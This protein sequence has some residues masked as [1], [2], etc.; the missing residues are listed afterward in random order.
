MDNCRSFGIGKGERIRIFYRRSGEKALGEVYLGD[1]RVGILSYE[2]LSS[3]NGRVGR[4]ELDPSH[5][6]LERLLLD[7]AL[8]DL[9]SKAKGKIY[10]KAHPGIVFLLLKY[11]FKPDLSI[12]EIQEM[13]HPRN[14]VRIEEENGGYKIS[15]REGFQKEFIQV[16]PKER[17]SLRERG[18]LG[19]HLAELKEEFKEGNVLLAGMDYVVDRGDIRFEKKEFSLSEYFSLKPSHARELSGLC[20]LME[21]RI[22]ATS[23]SKR[24]WEEVLGDMGIEVDLV[25]SDE[26]PLGCDIEIRGNRILVDRNLPLPMALD[27]ISSEIDV[28]LSGVFPSQVEEWRH[29]SIVKKKNAF[30]KIEKLLENRN[31]S[32]SARAIKAIYGEIP[33]SPSNV[34]IEKQFTRELLFK[35]FKEAISNLL[36][37]AFTIDI[38]EKL[39]LAREGKIN[40]PTPIS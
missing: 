40:L 35:D 39:S 24:S 8:K 15:Y 34:E 7:L 19:E 26:L 36:M 17:I 38:R 31:Y 10:V 9:F 12:E 32:R 4:I 2:I 5:Q 3:G 1:E 16:V 25:S 11:N 22:G 13:F 37:K 6:E 30:F 27:K 18:T 21:R 23:C 33:E 28:L 29:R 20:N 14:A